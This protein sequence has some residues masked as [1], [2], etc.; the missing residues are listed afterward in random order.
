MAK[1]LH[2][3]AQ[4][5]RADLN[6]AEFDNLVFQKGRD[7]YLETAI[8]C[9][10]KSDV[11][12]QQSNCKNC[13][14]TGW[15]FINKRKTRMVLTAIDVVNEYKPW[16]EELRG[17]VN[18][19]S[20]VED[21]LSIMDRITAIDGESIHNEVLFLRQ[22]ANNVFAYA[23]YDIKKVLYIALFNGENNKLD[24]LFNEV[25]FTIKNNV[26]LFKN[27]NFHF[28]KVTDN[29]ITIR[30]IHAPQFHVIEMRRD[31]MQSFIWSNNREVNQNLP[32]SAI[33]RR[34]HYQLS[35]QNINRDLLIDNSYD[36]TCEQNDNSNCP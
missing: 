20:H 8:Q 30:Y 24:R 17:T 14:G 29:S 13:G 5:P 19:T 2:T 1:L 15:V 32:V 34:A 26:I 21:E 18:V 9:P 35:G 23:T 11:T 25:D 27:K 6:K 12:N 22:K 4:P 7:V 28:D 36:T 3:F 16:S 33:A 10:C 31:T